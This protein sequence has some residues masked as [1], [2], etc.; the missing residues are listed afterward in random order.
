MSHYVRD[1]KNGRYKEIKGLDV[2]L[3]KTQIN[4]LVDNF[5]IIDLFRN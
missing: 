5:N 4:F 1:L 2:S 3:F